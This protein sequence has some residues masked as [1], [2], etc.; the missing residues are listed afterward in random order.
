MNKIL[1]FEYINY[2][3]ER[4]IRQVIPQKLVFGTTPHNSNKGWLLEAIDTEKNELRLFVLNHIQRIIGESIQRF[5]CVTVYPIDKH[6]RLLMINHKKLGVWLPPG[7][8]VDNNET[9]DEA[10]VRECL[11]ETGV[12][13]KLLGNKPSI[14]EGLITPLGIQC[15]QI[16]KGIRDHIDII[17]AA[18]PIENAEINFSE[19]EAYGCK[20]FSQEEI[21]KLKTF[22]SVHYWYNQI[23]EKF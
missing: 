9:P 16:E 12:K 2:K 20:W 5:F 6:K 22:D 3:G 10:A 11:E 8:K 21:K 13:I 4:K 23:I 1:K 14:K 19:R 15:N 18:T 7:G 17:Y